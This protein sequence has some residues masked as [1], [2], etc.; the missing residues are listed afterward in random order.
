VIVRNLKQGNQYELSY[1]YLI[2]SP[3]AL[4]SFRDPGIERALPLRTVE[5]VE[6]MTNAVVLAPDTR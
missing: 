5:D 3:G 4:P 2:L 6:R 1:D